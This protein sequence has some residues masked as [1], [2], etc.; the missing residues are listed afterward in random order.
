MEEQIYNQN[1]MFYVDF[2]YALYFLSPLLVIQHLQKIVDA[3]TGEQTPSS[4]Y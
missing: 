2:S 4:S 1:T 3:T